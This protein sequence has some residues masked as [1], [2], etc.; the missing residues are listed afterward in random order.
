MTVT[1]LLKTQVDQPVFEWMRFAP[2]SASSASSFTFNQ[3][4]YGRYMYYQVSQAMW[5]YDTYSDS[6]Q[7]T[8]PPPATPSTISQIKHTDVFGY[9]GHTI[10]ATS[11]TITI[12]GFGNLSNAANGLKIRIIAGMG[13]GQE[14]TITSSASAVIADF[15]VVSSASASAIGD[16]TKKWRFNQW[17]GYQCRLTFNTGQTQIR[18]ILYNDTTTLT[19]SDTNF[20]PIDPF[21][22]TGFSTV[23]PYAAP[24]TAGT[25]TGYVIEST[26]LTIDSALS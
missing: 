3:Y 14:R 12:A 4:T 18:K 25:V 6:W 11:T 8:S 26:T 1:N 24:T 13:A 22:N 5:R 10:S 19:F 16:N 2:T 20:Q 17:D 23:S 15:G 7:E 21:N 9:R